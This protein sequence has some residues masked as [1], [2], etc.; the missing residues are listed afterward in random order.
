MIFYLFSVGILFFQPHVQYFN[1][2]YAHVYLSIMSIRNFVRKDYTINDDGGLRPQRMHVATVLL[3]WLSRMLYLYNQISKFP[4][5][6]LN[7]VTQ[8]NSE[9]RETMFAYFERRSQ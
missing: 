3:L 1:I 5:A 7:G 8:L 9:V 4:S 6:T 2:H